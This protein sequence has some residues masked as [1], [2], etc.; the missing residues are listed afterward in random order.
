[1]LFFFYEKRKKVHHNKAADDS[2]LSIGIQTLPMMTNF[3]LFDLL[4]STKL[5]SFY[6]VILYFT[7]AAIYT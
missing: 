6:Y 7:K 2:T 1:M 3:R 5:E 4:A